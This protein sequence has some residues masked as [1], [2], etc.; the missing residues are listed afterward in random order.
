M[1]RNGKPKSKRQYLIEV[2]DPMISEF[3]K[4]TPENAGMDAE[5]LKSAFAILTN[6]VEQQRIPSA[7]AVVGRNGKI[8]GA[9]SV[10]YAVM[11]ANIQREAHTETLYDCASLTKVVV[12]LPLILKLVEK[13]LLDLDERVSFYIPQFSEGEKTSITLK[14]LLT[15]TSGLK[16]GL[17]EDLSSKSPEEVKRDIYSVQLDYKPG[18]RVVYSDLGFIIL[19]EIISKV[20]NESLEQT[21]K[22]TIFE[23][24]GMAN[25]LYN[26]QREMQKRIAATEF[27]ESLGDFQWGQVHDETASALGGVSGNAG[28]F[29]TAGDLARYA[30]MWLNQGHFKGSFIFS[31]LTLR[32]A[33]RNHTPSLHG[34]RGL[35]WVLKNDSFDVSGHLFTSNAY[36]HTGFTGTSLWMD[37]ETELFV[38]LLTNRVHFGRNRSINQLRKKFHNAVAASIVSF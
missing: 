4:T 7:V 15:H 34:N 36:G 37:P 30:Q 17:Q 2:G 27:R 26:P 20:L 3:E 11:V 32:L 25:S 35:G 23:P 8:I 12:T 38:V 5:R 14:H 31:P 18:T 10:G 28:L 19:G 13:G 16:S 1:G 9:H 22:E 6:E 33:L 21:A 29:A 24:L